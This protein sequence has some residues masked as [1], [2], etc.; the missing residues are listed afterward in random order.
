[1]GDCTC[2][3]DCAL[4]HGIYRRASP[5]LSCGFLMVEAQLLAGSPL[6]VMEEDPDT[7]QAVLNTVAKGGR[8]LRTPMP[9]AAAAGTTTIAT[10]LNRKVGEACIG[11]C[12]HCPE[13][14]LSSQESACVARSSM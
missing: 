11:Q 10:V 2:S 8:V 9:T 5:T 6:G 1:M 13:T 4:Q 14:M 3:T 7:K 12:L